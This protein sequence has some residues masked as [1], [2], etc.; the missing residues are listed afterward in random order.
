MDGYIDIHSHILP[1]LDDGSRSMEQTMSM[2]KIAYSDGIR[3]I[4]ATPHFREGNITT[5][6]QMME[7]CIAKVKCEMGEDIPQI[8]ILIG[9]EIYYSHEVVELIKEKL[10]P[11]MAGTRYVLVEFSPVAEYSYIKNGL[12]QFIFEGYIPILA[13]VERYENLTKDLNQIKD[14]ID[15]GAYIQVNAMSIIGEMGR[16]SKKIAKI[17]LKYNWIHLVATDAHSDGTRA[18]RLKKT[19]EYISKKYGE[20]YSKE[21]L[22][23][24]P[25]K[26]LNN[27][28]I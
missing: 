16:T 12:Q 19:I 24:N 1:Q 20:A 18:P 4:I 26:I 15:M 11:T 21:L 27:Q 6:K 8:N 25:S 17:L 7:D 28:Y 5:T 3:T 13:H 10:I 23:D 2:L 14:L 22:F 9:S